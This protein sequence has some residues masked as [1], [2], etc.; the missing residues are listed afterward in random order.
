MIKNTKAR[1]LKH[2]LD[3]RLP[4][5]TLWKRIKNLGAG[6]EQLSADS[7]FDSNE[8]NRMFLASY[9]NSAPRV[10]PRR[11]MAEVSPHSFSFHP[12]QDWE[13][14][15]A[16]WEIRSNATGLDELPICFLKLVLPLVLEKITY[17]F[18][19]LIATAT[20]PT[21]WKQAK[22]LPIRK[23]PHLNTLTNLRPI[24]I[25]CA[26]SKVFEKLLKQQATTF[27]SEN[28]LLS[29]SQ[30]GFRS[31]HSIKTATLR[32]YDDL[33]ATMDKKGTAILL[34]LDFSKA[35]DTI[36]HHSLCSKLASKFNFSANAVSLIESYLVGR[37]QIVF[38]G[39]QC[40][41]VGEVTSGVPQGSVIGPLLF[42]CYINDLPT[43]LKWCSIQMYADDV[44]IYIKRYGPCARELIRMINE[45]LARI[46]NWSDRNELHV[47][48]SKSKAIFIKGRRRNSIRTDSLSAIEM[49][50]QTIEWVDKA[51]NLGF[52]FQAD[53]EW[54]GLVNQ[55]CGKIYGCLRTLHS[56]ASAAPTYVRLKLFKALILPHFMFGD[57]LHV[58]PSANSMNQLQVALNSCI[59]YVYGLNR[60]SRVSHL[61]KNLIGCPLKNFFA[62]R[63]CMFLWKLAKTQSPPTL[64]QRL[65]PC[66]SQRS[67]NFIIPANSMAG[68]ASTLFVRGVVNWNMLPSTIKRSNSE[69]SFKRG[70]LEFWNR[71]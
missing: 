26:L 51:A 37:T 29:D 53:L 41:E 24:S 15:N 65:V 50:G 11:C 31:G 1:Y 48:Q 8:V 20:F 39:G 19:T 6:K 45:D 55:Q 57:L 14:V 35:F 36:P 4:A 34:L 43:V 21:C 46:A 60:Y 27:I 71:R 32:V 25:L 40:S 3:D 70:C 23:K 44:Q 49:N 66:R 63:S 30:A 18:N 52:V 33:A 12:V 68:Y 22:I 16:L 54:D 9:T 28:H 7:D 47:N 56:V 67:Q 17:I 38:S 10:T 13:V 62:Y 61:H 58:S 2:H 64:F 5:K 69:A 59:R 42:C